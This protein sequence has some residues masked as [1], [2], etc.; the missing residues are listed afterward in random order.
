M[1]MPVNMIT[2]IIGLLSFCLLMTLEVH[3]TGLSD[4]ITDWDP[5]IIQGPIME[6]GRDYIIVYEKKINLIDATIVGKR[7]K[8]IIKEGKGRTAEQ[9]DLKKG[10]IVFAKGSIGI[11][12]KSKGE[13]LFATEMYILPRFIGPK[14]AEEYKGLMDRPVPP[15]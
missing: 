2:K 4:A 14:D 9:D 3:A 7:F 12:D 8:T 6:V 11:D 13:T 1:K 5:G 15:K 10:I